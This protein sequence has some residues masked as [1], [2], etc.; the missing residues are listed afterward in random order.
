MNEDKALRL[1]LR[2]ADLQPLDRFSGDV[3]ERERKGGRL[4]T[5]EIERIGRGEG[6]T[7]NF[8]AARVGLGLNISH[9]PVSETKFRSAG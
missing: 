8:I 5:R 6:Q 3:V 9:H 1:V 7:L 2:H 4:I